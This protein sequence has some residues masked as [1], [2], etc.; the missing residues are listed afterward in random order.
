MT[1]CYWYER[2][3]IWD[4]AE[5]VGKIKMGGEGWIQEKREGQGEGTRE[6]VEKRLDWKGYGFA[7]FQCLELHVI[8]E[9]GKCCGM[10]FI[11]SSSNFGV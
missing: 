4:G 2:R 6:G 3:W 8:G 9:V 1:W 11:H 10:F 5:W 7:G